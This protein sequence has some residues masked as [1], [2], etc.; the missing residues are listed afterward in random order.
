[1]AGSG[2]GDIAYLYNAVIYN[3]YVP[4]NPPTPSNE[5]T[6]DSISFGANYEDIRM[7]IL[8]NLLWNTLAFCANLR[9]MTNLQQSLFR[10]VNGLVVWYSAQY[11][12]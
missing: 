4:T 5:D 1:M 11:W 8:S 6:D 9:C 7:Y 10:Y 3:D 2:S 12:L